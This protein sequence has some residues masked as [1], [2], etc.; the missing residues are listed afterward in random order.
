MTRHDLFIDWFWSKV[1]YD[2]E[3]YNFFIMELSMVFKV[4]V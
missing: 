3:L 1:V 2:S 4:T